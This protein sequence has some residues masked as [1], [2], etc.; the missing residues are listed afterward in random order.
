MTAEQRFERALPAILDDLY[1]GP[2]PDYRDDLLWQ[3][4][5]TTQRSAWSF[6]GRWL[7]MADLVTER[8]TAPRVP[9]RLAL[10]AALLLALALAAVAYVGSRPAPVPAPFG[11]ARTGSVVSSKGGDIFTADPATGT[12]TAITTGE[13]VDVDPIWSLDGTKISFIRRNGGLS[14]LYVMDQD[15]GHVT[16]LT[17][18][19]YAEIGSRTFS[20][21]GRR[22]AFA[23]TG[24]RQMAGMPAIL[25]DLY[26]A[27]ADGSGVTPLHVADHG[28]RL[29]VGESIAYRP[30][31]GD[32]ITFVAAP[33]EI[34]GYVDPNTGI[35]S[36]DPN[37]GTLRT[38]VP[39]VL[40]HW[41]GGLIWAPDGRRGAYHTWHDSPELTARVHIIDA[42]GSND[43]VLES[44]GPWNAVFSWSNDGT[45]IVMIRGAT[46][47]YE[48]AR[49]VAIPVAGG[50]PGVVMQ[51]DG[52]PQA[53]CC[54]AWLWAPDDSFILG[55]PTDPSGNPLPQVMW[56]PQTGMT[57]QPRWD[58]TSGPSLQRL[59][60]E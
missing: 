38:I 13:A 14:Q 40:E 7:P 39:P 49:I 53:E 25:D 29:N 16:L 18:D 46:G 37:G 21:D 26:V 17:P 28:L 41:T 48:G 54:G 45:R 9:W 43:R 23:A 35:Y 15:G 2:T 24:L 59:A 36:L 5:R 31:D 3:T 50:D 22:I 4:A 56:D 10:V 58:T 20:P 27:A 30:P 19:Q 1:L 6:P 44:T 52:E 42:D 32:E 57:S 47:G 60:T 33:L 8:I 11:P 55:N 51:Y 12:A 34:T